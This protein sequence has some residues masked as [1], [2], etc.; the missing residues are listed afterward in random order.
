MGFKL[1]SGNATS[2]KL[3]GGTEQSPAKHP[4][5]G[6]HHGDPGN[7]EAIKK[8]AQEQFKRHKEAHPERK[9]PAKDMKTG[10]Y[11]QSFEDSPAKQRLTKGG[12]GQDQNKIFNEKGE[13]VGDWING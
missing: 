6:D 4:T 12:E 9:S 5:H 3:M 7:K 13:H 10:S 8:A 11:K 2:F 1:K